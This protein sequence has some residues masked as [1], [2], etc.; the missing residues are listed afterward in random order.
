MK[1]ELSI[2]KRHLLSRRSRALSLVSLITVLGVAFGVMALLV[3][4]A[5]IKG[6]RSEYER[7]VLAFNAHVIVSCG[8]GSERE[9]DVVKQMVKDVAYPG[10]LK[11]ITPYLYR[12]G[13]AVKGSQ[14]RGMSIKAVHLDEYWQLSG[15]GHEQKEKSKELKGL[16]IGKVLRQEMKLGWDPLRF[17]LPETEESQEG[18]SFVELPL[19]GIFFSGI[20]DYDANLALID[21]AVAKDFL[22]IED[23]VD[24]LEIWLH[25][26]NQAASFSSRL[27]ERLSFPY[28]VMT[29]QDLNANLF[30]ALRLERLVFAIIMGILVLVSSFNISGTLT[31]RIIERRGDIAILRAMGARWR[32]IRRL[33]F[34]QGLFLGWTGCLLGLGLGVLVLELLIRLKP[35]KLAAE[36]YFIEFVPA[37]WSPLHIAIVIGVTTLFSWLATQMA[38]FRLK[39][40]SVVEALG[41]I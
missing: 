24:G 34:C 5:V 36:I 12:A 40:L 31:M 27:S 37:A 18:A 28:T 38:L 19:A 9:L 35:I 22:R 6:F 16:W 14:V 30:G 21:F 33:F 8:N 1:F 25:D 4:L 13:L 32:Q 7:S 17:R 26:P 41:E 11:G 29:W 10:E 23:E 2:G 15:L 3:A 39:R 20:Y